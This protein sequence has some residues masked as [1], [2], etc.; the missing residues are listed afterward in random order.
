MN[1]NKVRIISL[2]LVIFIA[3]AATPQMTSYP[4][5]LGTNGNNGCTCHS[6]GL[7]TTTVIVDGMPDSFTGGNTYDLTITVSNPDLTGAETSSNMGGFRL[8]ASAGTFSA[9]ENFT[10][11]VQESEGGV[12]HTELGNDVRS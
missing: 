2:L 3:L 6:G 1:K 4:T 11:L 7:G 5:G 12:T 10:D 8:F 9:G